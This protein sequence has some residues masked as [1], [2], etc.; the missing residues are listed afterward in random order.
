MKITRYTVLTLLPGILLAVILAFVTLER[1]YNN[2]PPIRSDGAGYHVWTYGLLSGDFSFC[3]YREILDPTLA[4]SY[5]NTEK[6]RCG[7][8]YP[9][10]VGVFQLPFV[11]YWADKTEFRNFSPGVNTAILW[12]ASA[13]LLITA[14]LTYRTLG[15]YGCAPK[16]RLLS[17]TALTFGGGLFHYATYDGSFS[18]IYSSFGV[19]GL[20]YLNAKFSTERPTAFQIILWGILAFWLYSVRQTNAAITLA[21]LAALFTYADKFSF[22]R[23]APAWLLATLAGLAVQ[24]AYNFYVSG[25][26]HIS[27]YGSESFSSIGGHFFDVLAS[28]ERGLLTYYPIWAL[29]LIAGFIYYRSPNTYLLAVIALLF[30]LV[31]GSWHSWYL[32]GGMGHRGFVELAPICIV[33]LGMSLQHAT[34]RAR[35]MLIIAMVPCLYVTCKVMLAYWAGH[36]P[37]LGATETMYW[38]TLLFWRKS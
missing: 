30:A 37:F 5:V 35:G 1:P 27:S 32:G 3:K 31:Y 26:L 15:L 29:V 34:P 25:E 22:K 11:S 19:S 10:G 20:L 38:K 18:H 21:M 17:I 13:L 16:W 36:F 9:P 28:Y 6:G 4:I 33:V 23:I 7:V 8:K 24:M 2:S 14:A 12:L